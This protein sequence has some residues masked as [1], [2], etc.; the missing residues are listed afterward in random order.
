MHL[1]FLQTEVTELDQEK[2]ALLDKFSASKSHLQ[3]VEVRMHMHMYVQ[4]TSM[5]ELYSIYDILSLHRPSY[6]SES[7]PSSRLL[8]RGT[9]WWRKR[10]LWKRG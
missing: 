5:K 8:S 6:K 1:L 4:H 2:S 9:S 3:D 10:L 7:V